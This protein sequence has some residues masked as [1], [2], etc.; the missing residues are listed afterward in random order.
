[1]KKIWP[2]ISAFLAGALTIALV[3]W[4]FVGTTFK[5]QIRIRQRGRDNVL[6]PTIKAEIKPRMKRDERKQDRIM[7]RNERRKEKDLKK[8]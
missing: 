2:Y 5:G 8:L 6:Q 1:M 7:R 4:K 3:A